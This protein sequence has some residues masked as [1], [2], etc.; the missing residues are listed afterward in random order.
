MSFAEYKRDSKVGTNLNTKLM[1]K[2]LKREDIVGA[3]GILGVNVRGS[4]LE[5][6]A[7]AELACIMDVALHD[8]K[9]GG[10]RSKVQAYLED[11][12][13]DTDLE[14]EMLEA[15]IR[16][17]TSLFRIEE[18]DPRRRTVRLSDQLR[19]GGGDVII[20]DGDLAVE[21]EEGDSVFARICRRPRFC[22]TSGIS[23]GFAE[24]VAPILIRRYRAMRAKPNKRGPASR[25]ALFFRMNRRHGLQAAPS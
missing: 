10:G 20:H 19:G 21:P 17:K 9:D 4:E 25:F 5:I 12:G 14:R 13:A 6:Y 7:D 24:D 1:T 3:A 8:V 16:A 22:T 11:V 15:H 2:M 23:L 18:C